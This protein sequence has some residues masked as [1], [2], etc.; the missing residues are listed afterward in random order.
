[1]GAPV[2]SV[3]I[4]VGT[5]VDDARIE[6]PDLATLHGDPQV[7]S[8][9]PAQKL[10]LVA[11]HHRVAGPRVAPVHDGVVEHD[12]AIGRAEL[13]RGFDVADDLIADDVPRTT[14]L[15]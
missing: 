9:H 1:M 6:S 11:A 10:V 5:P 8:R 12:E 15:R 14:E 7:V 3:V 2:E 13:E 4:D